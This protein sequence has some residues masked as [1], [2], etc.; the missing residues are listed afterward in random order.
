MKEKK[1]KTTFL[2]SDS[3]WG[4]EEHPRTKNGNRH[5]GKARGQDLE[6]LYNPIVRLRFGSEE[7]IKA[8]KGDINNLYVTA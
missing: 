1:P 3:D 6:V 8:K 7:H 4:H 2:I 5:D